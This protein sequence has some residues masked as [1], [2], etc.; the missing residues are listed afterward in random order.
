[1]GTGGTGVPPGDGRAWAEEE[2]HEP[3]AKVFV[4][5]KSNEEV[6]RGQQQLRGK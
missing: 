5:R 4:K 1:M 2:D 3:D 6:C